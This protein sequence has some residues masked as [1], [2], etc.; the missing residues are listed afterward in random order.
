M[1]LHSPGARP[2]RSAWVPIGHC[3]CPAVAGPGPAFGWETRL[4]P[5]GPFLR[6]SGQAGCAVR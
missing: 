2:W 1:R 6:P 3:V 5:L 4:V